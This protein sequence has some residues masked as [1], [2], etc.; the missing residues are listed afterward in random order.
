MPNLMIFVFF[1][2]FCFL[3]NVQKIYLF[4][5]TG[6]KKLTLA[7]RGGFSFWT[8]FVL[9]HLFSVFSVTDIPIIMDKV[10]LFWL[11][12]CLGSI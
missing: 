8:K 6:N 3:Y 12:R 7:V 1:F 11:S 4:G 2:I 9:S 10:W 5:P